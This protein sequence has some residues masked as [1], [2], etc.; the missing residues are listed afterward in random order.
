M[1]RKGPSPSRLLKQGPRARILEAQL[2]RG[3][4]IEAQSSRCSVCVGGGVGKQM[5][6]RKK[7]PAKLYRD[8][9]SS[10]AT[11]FKE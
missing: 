9:A 6:K 7:T 5:E 11:V 8:Q 1:A 2:K 10:C 3:W 4:K